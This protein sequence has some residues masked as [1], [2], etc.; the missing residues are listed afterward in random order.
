MNWLLKRGHWVYALVCV[1]ALAYCW[2]DYHQKNTA[3]EIVSSRFEKEYLSVPEIAQKVK[4]HTPAARQE[5]WGLRNTQLAAPPK[6]GNSSSVNMGCTLKHHKKA[7]ILIVNADTKESWAFFGVV[8]QGQHL[9]AI[10]RNQNLK[11]HPVRMV[12]THE[13][14]TQGVVVTQIGL[15]SV[16]LVCQQS[17]DKQQ[18]KFNVFSSELPHKGL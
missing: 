13:E 15:H 2:D 17:D 9:S 4:P 8:L 16:T 6:K 10:F 7:D 5:V 11:D 12:S 18:F 3:A 14:L 1:I